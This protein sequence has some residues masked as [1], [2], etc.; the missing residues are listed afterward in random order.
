[1]PQILAQVGLKS[2]AQKEKS[3]RNLLR[4]FYERLAATY[5]RGSYTTTTIGLAV[6]DG[7]VRNGNG[8]DHC[9]IATKLL[10]T[11]LTCQII[12]KRSFPKRIRRFSENYTQGIKRSGAYHNS[13]VE[14]A[15]S[16][17]EKAIKPHDRLV[18]VN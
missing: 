4:L 1:M 15:F 10:R 17:K 12:L 8:S 18:L 6:F 13:R 7:R 14:I 3:R 5:S 2:S 16:L 9:G 11:R